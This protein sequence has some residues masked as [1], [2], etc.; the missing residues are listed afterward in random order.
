MLQQL[1]ERMGKED[2][3]FVITPNNEYNTTGKHELHNI[4]SEKPILVGFY[5]IFRALIM[6]WFFNRFMY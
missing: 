6:D 2:Y 1:I 4:D 3:F 5:R